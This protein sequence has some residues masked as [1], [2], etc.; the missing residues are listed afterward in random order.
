MIKKLI[1]FIFKIFGSKRE[2]DRKKDSKSDDIYPM[3]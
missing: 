1:N 2:K 3:W